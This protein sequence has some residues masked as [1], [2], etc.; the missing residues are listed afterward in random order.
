[1]VFVISYDLNK[2]AQKYN[3]LYKLIET[4][5]NNNCIHILESTYIIKST[6]SSKEIYEFLASA[7][8]NNDE[9]FISEVTNNHYGQLKSDDWPNVKKLFQ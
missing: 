8:D 6:K 4:I 7:L 1:M 5:S 2:P 9:L 3:E